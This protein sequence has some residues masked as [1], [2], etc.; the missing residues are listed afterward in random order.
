MNNQF[1][2]VDFLIV[3]FIVPAS[4]FQ[5]IVPCVVPHYAD[6]PVFMAS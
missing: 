5:M 4:V 3:F 1:E 2:R 6:M